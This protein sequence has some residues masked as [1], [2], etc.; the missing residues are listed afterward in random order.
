M[1]GAVRPR[2]LVVAAA[3]AGSL[4]VVGA[5]ATAAIWAFRN[6][7]QRSSSSTG[8]WI[9][10]VWVAVAAA[11]ALVGVVTAVAVRSARRP[12]RDLSLAASRLQGERLPNAL[13]AIETGSAPPPVQPFVA[14]DDLQPVADALGHLEEVARLQASRARRAEH[15]IEDLFGAAADRIDARAATADAS[16]G[17]GLRREAAALRVVAPG[18]PWAHA[19]PVGTAAPIAETLAAAAATTARPDLVEVGALEPVVVASDASGSVLLTIA[20]LLDAATESDTRVAVSGSIQPEGYHLVFESVGGDGGEKLAGFSFALQ[21]RETEGL[22]FG[23]RVAVE[24]ARDARLLL[25][26]T[27]AEPVVQWHVLVPAGAFVAGS[28]APGVVASPPPASEPEPE[29]EPEP[30]VSGPDSDPVPEL[31]I[32]LVASEPGAIGTEPPIE[33]VEPV[34]GAAFAVVEPANGA[35]PRPGQID[36]AQ[37]TTARRLGE[38]LANLLGRLEVAMARRALGDV[39]AEAE[40]TALLV[41]GTRLVSRLQQADLC[42]SHNQ[43]AL[44][45]A[46]DAAVEPDRSPPFAGSGHDG[47]DLP[48]AA[49][50]QVR[51]RLAALAAGV[52]IPAG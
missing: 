27:V 13:R 51:E 15:R 18:S 3:G 35:R 31:Y 22:S 41:D 21:S 24:A 50:A 2:V 52:V 34:V 17:D 7:P 12:L 30:V 48:Y 36:L 10:L 23:L 20:E 47:V 32:D 5:I 19:A 28:G 39:A 1:R 33:P 42:D 26:L 40:R 45:L 14:P 4:V 8:G 16:V 44:L 43:R 46:I 38:A 11:L 6:G 25:W 29:P 37:L 9:L 49:L